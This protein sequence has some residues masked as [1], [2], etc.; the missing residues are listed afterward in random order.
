MKKYSI[1][2]YYCYLDHIPSEELCIYLSQGN[3]FKQKVFE[4]YSHEELLYYIVNYKLKDFN[5]TMTKFE[6]Y[7]SMSSIFN[8]ISNNY[9][10]EISRTKYIFKVS[11]NDVF[12]E[13]KFP[14]DN[15]GNVFF[16]FFDDFYFHHNDYNKD[17]NIIFNEQ[18]LELRFHPHLF[19]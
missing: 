7:L 16:T 8:T 13:D 3:D 5:N 15:Y 11:F 2:A 17:F 10:I 18:S 4:S 12:P 1:E 19:K 6:E 9:N 14:H